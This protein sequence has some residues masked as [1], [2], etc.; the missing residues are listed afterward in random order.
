MF[1]THDLTFLVDP[2]FYDIPGMSIIKPQFKYQ[3]EYN[4]AS[5]PMIDYLLITHNHYDHL[6]IKTLQELKPKIKRVICP[7]DNMHYLDGIFDRYKITEMDW[8]QTVQLSDTVKIRALSGKHF[9]S[10]T[11]IDSMKALWA[12]Y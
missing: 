3:H 12:G 7:L 1:R 8:L 6:S 11:G 10:R 4:L 9:T 2:I 5:L